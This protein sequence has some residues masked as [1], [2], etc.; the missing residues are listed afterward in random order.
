VCATGRPISNVFAANMAV[1]CRKME[2]LLAEVYVA[3]YGGEISDVAFQLLPPSPV[4]VRNID[5]VKTMVECGIISAN[6][7]SK[8]NELSIAK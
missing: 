1:L 6:T 3:T 5:D 2:L 8:Y 4:Q 7:A